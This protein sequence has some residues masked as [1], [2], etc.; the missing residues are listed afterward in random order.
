MSW[1]CLGNTAETNH[2]AVLHSRDNLKVCE[3][4]WS[5]RR[6][7]L[8]Q[9]IKACRTHRTPELRLCKLRYMCWQRK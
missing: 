1:G 6:R 2:G 9:E 7:Q 4:V 8:W 3:E 5:R